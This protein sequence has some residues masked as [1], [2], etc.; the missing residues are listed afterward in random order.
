MGWC[1]AVLAATSESS[2]GPTSVART[3]TRPFL[4]R[5]SDS[6]VMTLG[7][8]AWRG[9]A[10]PILARRPRTYRRRLRDRGSQGRAYAGTAKARRKERS[11][12][13]LN[14]KY[15][16]NR[17][18]TQLYHYY[19]CSISIE[20]MSRG[21]FIHRIDLFHSI[22]TVIYKSK[23]RHLWEERSEECLIYHYHRCLAI[24]IEN[25]SHGIFIH[26]IDLFDSI[27]TVI[28]KSNWKIERMLDLSLSSLFDD[29]DR[30]YVPWKIYL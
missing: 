27:A 11:S 28:C 13:A 3:S 22:A 12:T 1:M 19:C 23:G 21:K 16:I 10:W 20:N 9:Q 17:Q 6:I 24:S 14:N 26:R 4:L 30:K 15:T 29:L 8:V 7:A 2:G 5:L 18:T 25:M